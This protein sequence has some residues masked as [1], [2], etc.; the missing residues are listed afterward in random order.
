MS[1]INQIKSLLDDLESDISQKYQE[2]IDTILLAHQKEIEELKL[3]HEKNMDDHK[4]HLTNFTIVQRMSKEI[5]DYQ[6]QLE[7]SNKKIERLQ[8]LLK[9]NTKENIK[10]KTKD[11]T[12][13]NTKVNT[14]ENAEENT[15][16]NTKEDIKRNL[17]KV[18][19]KG[20]LY[21]LDKTNSNE[22]QMVYEILDNDELGTL[23]GK[24]LLNG[25]YRFLK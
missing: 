7:L 15:K 14:A 8:H 16:E 18:K 10:E 21:Y 9:E 25:K 6:R 13:E 22:E 3:L 23:V 2:K 5:T 12:V 11:N 17:V 20:T 19:L 1:S 4:T 24:K